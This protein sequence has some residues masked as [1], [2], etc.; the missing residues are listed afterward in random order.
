[1]TP[2]SASKYFAYLRRW[3]LRREPEFGMLASLVSSGRAVLDVGANRGVYTQAL[4]GLAPAVHAF[5]PN[6]ALVARLSRLRD[7]RLTIHPFALGDRDGEA[8]LKVPVSRWGRSSTQRATIAGIEPSRGDRHAEIQ[9]P[10]RRLDSIGVSDVGFIKIDV[11]GFETQV[12]DGARE[13][14][15]R[16]RPTMLI[17][18]EETHTKQPPSAFIDQL[19]AL[20]YACY[21]LVGGVL[22]EAHLVDLNWTYCYN[23]IF[24]PRCGPDRKAVGR[25]RPASRQRFSACAQRA[26]AARRPRAAQ[27][28]RPG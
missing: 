23:W 9:V 10:V 20:G 14:L 17:E 2:G 1:M 15:E 12:I 6:P 24:L 18:I 3:L 27:R 21:A 4:L 25:S 28:L 7:P 16:C 8:T 22:T 11:E 26:E 19:A 5:E 13:T